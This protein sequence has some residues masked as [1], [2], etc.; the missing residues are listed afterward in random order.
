MISQSLYCSLCDS[1]Q[2]ADIVIIDTDELQQFLKPYVLV[3]HK[4]SGRGFYLDRQYRH[5]V[6]ISNCQ[7]PKNPTEVGRQHL[8]AGSNLPAWVKIEKVKGLV[9][10]DNFDTFWL[11]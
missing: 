9:H 7:E 11:Y 10:C 4:P 6:D 8:T 3:I 1:I 2:P 5:I